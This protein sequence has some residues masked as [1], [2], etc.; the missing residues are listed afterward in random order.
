MP[1]NNQGQ[2]PLP[3]VTQYVLNLGKSVA[4][5]T[6][7]EL[8]GS[9]ENTADFIETNQ[10]LFKDI[11]AGARN[12]K[13]T[14]QLAQKSIQRS[15]VYE[16]G[17]GLRDALFDSIR[18]GRFY[19]PKR[20]AEYQDKA[21]GS[22]GVI[23]DGDDWGFNSNT[24]DI[25]DGDD[26]TDA[27]IVTS[28]M[29]DAAT[30]Q[31]GI[32]AKAAEYLA[33][34]EKA[35]TKL[36]FAQGEKMYST[37]TNGLAG[38]QTMLKRVNEFLEGPLTTHIENSTKFYTETTNILRSIEG[39]VKES[40]EMQRNIYKSKQDQQY[41]R[42]QFGELG[43]TAPDLKE[44]AKI[45]KKN[46]YDV[47]PSEVTMLLGNDGDDTNLLMGLVA[48]PLEF[49]PAYAA[50]AL[51]PKMVKN[52][53]EAF[54]QTMTGVFGQFIARM[55]KAAAN[56]NYDTPQWLETLGKI[57]G[58]RMKTKTSI[59]PSKYEKGAVPFDGIVKKAIID[60]IPGH[61]ARIEAA[62]TGGS[63]RVFDFESGKWTN[64]KTIAKENKQRQDRA[65]RDA[66]SEVTGE[67]R[68][69]LAELARH[70]MERSKDLEAQFE[71]MLR[72]IYE[73]RG[74]FEPFK[75]HGYGDD[76][77]AAW[78]YYGFDKESD[79][80]RA[81]KSV[82]RDKGKAMNMANDAMYAI[83]SLA[84]YY[85]N[86]ESGNGVGLGA[87]A[88][89]LYN[90]AFDKSG[91]RTEIFKGSNNIIT[92][93]VDEYNHNLF[94][95]LRN[96]H[97]M[98]GGTGAGP[99]NG[100]SGGGGNGPTGSGNPYS[101]ENMRR[102]GGRADDATRYRVMNNIYESARA[103]GANKEKPLTGE[104]FD[105][106]WDDKQIAREEEKRIRH[107]ELDHND[108]SF[109]D[110]LLKAST[111]GK[112]W[113][114]IQNGLNALSKKPALYLTG[115]LDT[116]DKRIFTL[117]FGGKE[118]EDKQIVDKDGNRIKGFLDYLIFKTQE[119]FDKL[120]DWI[121][122]HVLTRLKKF[123]DENDKVKKAKQFGKDVW[124]RMKVQ[125][126][127]IKDRVKRGWAN[128]YGAAWDAWKYRRVHGGM[129]QD[130]YSSEWE[131]YDDEVE[132]FANGG[133]IT[134]RGL[135]VVSPGERIIPNN[136]NRQHSDLAAERAFARAHGLHGV[137]YY[138]YGSDF[139]R[140]YHG[141]AKDKAKQ[142][143]DQAKQTEETIK[144][145]AKE[146]S[147]GSGG[148][149]IADVVASTLIGGGFTTLAGV[150][151][152][153]LL[154]AA[155]GSAVGIA[156][157]SQ[158][159]QRLLFGEDVTD[160]KGNVVDHKGG[161][162]P[163]KLQKKLNKYLPTM[164]DFGIAGGLL[165]LLTP[166]GLIGGTMMGA[167]VGFAKENDKFQEFLWGNDKLGPDKKDGLFKK[168]FRE[169]LKKAAPSML[170]GAAGAAL[171]GPFGLLGNAVMGSAL[172]FATTTDAFKNAILG[173]E[174]TDE[175]GKKHRVGGLVGA[176]YGGLVL[177]V[178][179]LGLEILTQG[180]NF[181]EKTVI[182]S[183]AMF[184]KSITQR[185][186]NGVRNIGDNFSRFFAWLGERTSGKPL[187]DFIGHTIVGN[188]AKL[189]KG[190][191]WLPGKIAKGAINAPFAAMRGISNRIT[192]NQVKGGSADNMSAAERKS[193]RAAHPFRTGGIDAFNKADTE[194]ESM[195]SGE[196]AIWKESTALALNARKHMGKKIGDLVKKAGGYIS[197]FFNQPS[198][199][200]H[201]Y[202]R[203]NLCGN[204]NIKKVHVSVSKGR[205]DEVESEIRVFVRRGKLTAEEGNEFLE[206]IKEITLNI[207][208]EKDNLANVRDLR[209]KAMKGI[210]AKF[211]VRGFGNIRKLSRL[212]N[213]EYD[214][215]GAAEAE[216]KANG[217]AE[218]AKP[219]NV[220]I[221]AMKSQFDR[222]I[223]PV[224]KIAEYLGYKEDGTGEIKKETMSPIEKVKEAIIGPDEEGVERSQKKDRIGIFGLIHKISENGFFRVVKKIL[225]VGAGVLVGGAALGHLVDFVQRVVWPA[226]K[227]IAKR[228]WEGEDGNGGVKG[229][230]RNIWEGKDGKGGIKGMFPK[231][232]SWVQEKII[233]P[234]KKVI[235]WIK[236]GT[237]WENVFGGV[238][239]WFKSGWTKLNDIVIEP[240][241]TRLGVTLYNWW[242]N[243]NKS[244]ENDFLAA[245]GSKKI[246]ENG[247]VTSTYDNST[248]FNRM[249]NNIW[250][251][252]SGH[253]F[254]TE[255]KDIYGREFKL[256]QE[257]DDKQGTISIYCKTSGEYIIIPY[258]N[259]QMSN[260]ITY[261]YYCDNK[262][263]YV[264]AGAAVGAGVAVGMTAWAASASAAAAAATATGAGLTAS[265]VGAPIG[266][267][268]LIG[269]AVL[270]LVLS[271]SGASIGGSIYE[272]SDGKYTA[273]VEI[274]AKKLPGQ[275]EYICGFFGWNGDISDWP[276]FATD[277]KF[278]SAVKS[279]AID[280][281]SS[282]SMAAQ[283]N[284]STGNNIATPTTSGKPSPKSG[285]SFK[286]TIINQSGTTSIEKTAWVDSS[287]VMH[288]K[289]SRGDGIKLGL[290]I[291]GSQD[292]ILESQGNGTYK[293]GNK[294]GK[295]RSKDRRNGGFGHIYQ[296]DPA[297][298]GLKFGN[299][300]FG[301]AGCGPVAAANLM[302]KMS[303]GGNGL[304]AAANFATGYQNS[305]GSVS[306]DYFTDLF[307]GYQTSNKRDL[308][309]KIR[310]GVPTFLLGHSNGQNGT[311]FGS[312]DHYITAM[313]TDKQG[314]IIAED[315]DLPGSSYK[316]PANKVLNDTTVGM[317]TAGKARSSKFRFGKFRG[318][319]A[320]TIR[321]SKMAERSYAMME[322]LEAG[323][324]YGAVNKN[325]N[326]ALSIGKIQWHGCRAHDLMMMVINNMGADQAREILGE[327]LYKE[328]TTKDRKY[329]DKRIIVNDSES[330][331][332]SALISTPIGQRCQDV[333]AMQNIDGYI[334]SIKKQGVSE[335]NA[336]LYCA[337]FQNQ[338]GSASK[339]INACKSAG[340]SL[341]LDNL[342]QTALQNFGKYASRRQGCYDL[343]KK[344]S[345]VGAGSIEISDIASYIL[346]KTLSQTTVDLSS[347]YSMQS[348]GNRISDQIL[349]QTQEQSNALMDKIFGSGL[350]NVVRNVKNK[351]SGAISGN[352]TSTGDTSNYAIAPSTGNGTQKS[353]V[354]AMASKMGQLKYSQEG[355]KQNPD[356]GS[357]SCAST[358]AWAY[359][360]ALGIRPGDSVN[361]W[362]YMSSTQQ[363][364]DS[365]FKTIY[366]NNGRDLV[367]T[368][369]LQ[370]GDIMYYNWKQTANN[371]N[372][373]HTEM[374]AGN[375][376][377]LS[378]G[379]PGLGPTYRNLTNGR[380]KNLMMVRR[381]KG[382]G[383]GGS[384]KAN[385]IIRKY[386]I[387]TS[388]TVSTVGNNYNMV[389]Q[390]AM[391]DR[392]L[393]AI[394]ELLATIATNTEG[395]A[396]V[397][398]AL[399]QKG[400]QIDY[401]KL[402]KAAGNARKRAAKARAE[403]SK[404]AIDGLRSL[405][406]DDD[407]SD[408]ANSP[409]ATI[410]AAMEKLASD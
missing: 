108:T 151:G 274:S 204:R 23:D 30:A 63:E 136:R 340:L 260:I 299:S 84:R 89:H 207:S 227:P 198:D 102:R 210:G 195:N 312:G 88:R 283:Y 199:V 368:N 282:Y 65:I 126:S 344:T 103:R 175:T 48:N 213:K 41:K 379:G 209:A 112:K 232:A 359:K 37:V 253:N 370:P 3:K 372:M 269:G 105:K 322:Q 357:G 83:E 25:K 306:P 114:V 214:V 298:S 62:L 390:E 291:K 7:K 85:E 185:I 174:E 254:K 193:F 2:K 143:A 236:E 235:G 176:L 259:G 284:K 149:G 225:K 120:N 134:R 353:I 387:N 398:K 208:K 347:G 197:E 70:D 91:N 165:G 26:H 246:N 49:I 389:A 270:G 123:L 127:Q 342:H 4:Y 303:G 54:D 289:L 400:V 16:A 265:G 356:N 129:S 263:N 82:T 300:T 18:S 57:F 192:A 10:E 363:A 215:K 367:D 317:P 233:D 301:E 73:D 118:T 96:I 391:Y 332:I 393:G 241:M 153:P 324:R 76:K 111:L 77:M 35:S 139:Y 331:K 80:I 223:D 180:K 145:V 373:S 116:A 309:K 250:G 55:N 1:S 115:L 234:F 410:V 378:H 386:G 109:L 304:A 190:A 86:A 261:G 272:T 47:L 182:P 229:F 362:A 51:I 333:L 170:I 305:D 380:K 45:V 36:L 343:I 53:I 164:G 177:P 256:L 140:G 169:K 325:D 203:Y 29:K 148:K 313:G 330:K 220:V 155:V 166:M 212:I 97:N 138:A 69:Y 27:N 162:I 188:A 34:S 358:V 245:I 132:T 15:K 219:E 87:T 93:A 255:A 211:G 92:Q 271:F 293:V 38:T 72:K 355:S 409:T 157:N 98:M 222:V 237:F 189:A 392:F 61:L 21:G 218:A 100:P 154:G 276:A 216:A 32:T 141:K 321:V 384:A 374:Y 44:Y 349:S 130:E 278:D 46:L 172:G 64:I 12:Y 338:Y 205:F 39:L 351:V 110:S 66:T 399:A 173:K 376:Q 9:A 240:I 122:E 405:I 310:A 74:I 75:A 323:G 137:N 354:D 371:G 191:L 160:E 375:N 13:R 348:S 14:A 346:N 60:V 266:L 286:V 339:L 20:E 101:R 31:A 104:E 201:R 335:E 382:F 79:F 314:N 42:S 302:N 403:Q 361:G 8:K 196:L 311:P 406:G 146:V 95:Y 401:E 142:A 307:G 179:R 279:G 158:T 288:V 231:V 194:L 258:A 381:Y 243:R 6:A 365:N 67:Y 71:G 43:T 329:W 113:E 33:E 295:G 230:F 402:E 404:N 156:K 292:Y 369:K 135:A 5:A 117:F 50:K 297:I 200:D 318:G 251:N 107:G 326:G 364:K 257:G 267:P 171:F 408:L 224:T 228:I 308:M 152:G 226:V 290:E 242:Q 248:S 167:A 19:D 328:I 187:V 150:V 337:D 68:S 319:K 119:S 11:Y 202:S 360:K 394:I 268:V 397:Q 320:N 221:E 345:K 90:N 252:G 99:V 334:E 217:E 238:L 352:T 22:L 327:A 161:L 183:T 121:D 294:Y 40:T 277:A 395:L 147:K 315:P 131:D 249:K 94:Y 58:L 341:T 206:N 81:A 385:D 106:L 262:G 181:L 244:T 247:S 163:P 133:L 396:E 280:D 336:I 273:K 17:V 264:T 366:T 281:A 275:F 125:G 128:T 285:G 144:K 407:M 350:M 168:E 296:N 159:V 56:P 186:F 24:F 28:A 388:N 124:A 316:Y 52:S 239:N 383:R 59:D 178:K 78:E 377:D 287:G 184:L